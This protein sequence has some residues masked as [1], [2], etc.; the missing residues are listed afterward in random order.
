MQNRRNEFATQMKKKI[1]EN[2]KNTKQNKKNN[3]KMSLYQRF[4]EHSLK[5]IPQIS[6]LD[7]NQFY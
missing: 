4:P 5:H 6:K 2:E 7:L 1:I 3:E